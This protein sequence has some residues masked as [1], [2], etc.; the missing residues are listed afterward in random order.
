MLNCSKWKTK[1]STLVFSMNMAFEASVVLLGRTDKVHRGCRGF[2]KKLLK[3]IFYLGQM[4]LMKKLLTAS[5]IH[6]PKEFQK[7]V[8][9]HWKKYFPEYFL[10]QTVQNRHPLLMKRFF[11]HEERGT[12]LAGRHFSTLCRKTNFLYSLH[13]VYIYS[14][15]L[16]CYFSL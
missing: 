7:N 12:K 15:D 10:Q 13:H 11:L 4:K 5:M 8:Q 16:W 6:I 1:K 2:S 14:N 3:W 9:Y